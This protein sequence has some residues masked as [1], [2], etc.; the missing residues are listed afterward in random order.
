MLCLQQVALL[1]ETHAA[2][3]ELRLPRS[4]LV[5]MSSRNKIGHLKLE[6]HGEMLTGVLNL[7]FVLS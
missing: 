5:R 6:V 4:V 7:T 1:V 3:Q 2:R